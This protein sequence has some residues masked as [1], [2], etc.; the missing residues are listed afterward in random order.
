MSQSHIFSWGDFILAIY[1]GLDGADYKTAKRVFKILHPA[2]RVRQAPGQG[3]RVEFPPPEGT[4]AIS[5]TMD[6]G[7][8]V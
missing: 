6:H 1:E 4:S 5:G 2:A 7:G 8:E 3:I